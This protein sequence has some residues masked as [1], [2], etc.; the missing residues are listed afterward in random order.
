MQEIYMDRVGG[1]NANGGAPPNPLE[2]RLGSLEA[3]VVALDMLVSALVTTSDQ[4]V[5]ALSALEQDMVDWAKRVTPVAQGALAKA[6]RA[7]V[8]RMLKNLRELANLQRKR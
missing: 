3:K 2:A 5:A 8:K 6:A 7:E 4:R 1:S